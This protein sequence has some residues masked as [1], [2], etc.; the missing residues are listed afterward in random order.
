MQ[1]SLRRFFCRWCGDVIG[2]YER[3][4]IGTDTD[5]RTTSIAAEPDLAPCEGQYHFHCFEQQ[6]NQPGRH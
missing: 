1:A 5:H 3:M 6:R 2:V 4:I